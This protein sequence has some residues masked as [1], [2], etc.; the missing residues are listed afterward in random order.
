MIEFDKKKRADHQPAP[1][2]RVT[3]IPAHRDNKG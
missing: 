1:L 3:T 2:F